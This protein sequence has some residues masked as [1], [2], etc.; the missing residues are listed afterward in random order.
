MGQVSQPVLSY[1][2]PAPAWDP[3]CSLSLG[4][5]LMTSGVKLT[6]AHLPMQASLHLCG[7][8]VAPSLLPPNSCVEWMSPGS[9]VAIRVPQQQA[10]M[11]GQHMSVVVLHHAAHTCK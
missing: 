6:P 11:A 1:L 10:L 9:S 2:W 7:R 4:Y 8:A 5:L 3:V